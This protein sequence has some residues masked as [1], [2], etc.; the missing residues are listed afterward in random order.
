VAAMLAR[1]EQAV[2]ITLQTSRFRHRVGDHWVREL[3]K[4]LPASEYPVFDVPPEH[5]ILAEH[6]RHHYR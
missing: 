1:M 6:N 3:R 5:P 4:V 2:N